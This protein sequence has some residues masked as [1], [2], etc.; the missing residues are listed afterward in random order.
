MSAELLSSIAGVVLSLVFSYVP[1]LNTKF[2]ALE[3]EV[4]RS[5]MLGLLAL[6][7]VATYGLACSGWLT[8]LFGIQVP[9][10]QSGIQMLIQAF[11]YAAITNQTAYSLSP[12][13]QAV[14][15]AKA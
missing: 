6:A 10:D 9:C 7:A 8:G 15:Q 11:I 4:K 5:I 13:T 14:R 2:A 3:T 1:K 12:K